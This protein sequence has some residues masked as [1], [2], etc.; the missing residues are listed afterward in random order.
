MATLCECGCGRNADY[1]LVGNLPGTRDL[2]GARVFGECADGNVGDR[3]RT[4]RA[5]AKAE[6]PSDTIPAPRWA[7]SPQPDAEPYVLPASNLPVRECVSCSKPE[8]PI[9]ATHAGMCVYCDNRAEMKPREHRLHGDNENARI[10]VAARARMA[11]M[12]RNERPRANAETRMLAEGEWYATKVYPV[13]EDF[14]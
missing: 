12:D 13:V 9:L 5:K 2:V 3:I 1:S 6:Q 7:P 10:S 4:R 8:R 14:E 11:K